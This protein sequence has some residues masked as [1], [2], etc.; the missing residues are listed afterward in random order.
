M[1]AVFLLSKGVDVGSWVGVGV[2][3]WDGFDRFCGVQLFQKI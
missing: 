2:N 1:G 3:A